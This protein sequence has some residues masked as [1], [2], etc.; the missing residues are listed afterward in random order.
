MAEFETI[1]LTN[2][3][4]ERFTQNY[5]G[6][7]YTLEA[8]ETRAFSKHVGFHVAKHLSNRIIDEDFR[9]EHK[10]KFEGNPNADPAVRALHG[11]HA[12]LM[13]FDNPLRR[14]ALYKILGNE[15]TVVE[16]IAAYPFPSIK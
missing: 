6:E 11:E 13:V 4:S 1:T 5:N 8:N 3:T 7:P 16:V 15:Q 10:K 12:Q 14:I 9:K 2:P